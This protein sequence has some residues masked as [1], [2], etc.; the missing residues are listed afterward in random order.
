LQRANL[1]NKPYNSS[2]EKMQ[3]RINT[4]N[5]HEIKEHKETMWNLKKR[6]KSEE[7]Q[8]CI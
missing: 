2:Y 3:S 8:K 6:E 4:H 7:L 5:A 1:E